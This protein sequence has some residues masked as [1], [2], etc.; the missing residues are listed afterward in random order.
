M[1]RTLVTGAAGMIGS[2]LLERLEAQAPGSA[3]GAWFLP[4]VRIEELA[5]LPLVELDVRDRDA[6]CALISA[7]RPE[8]IYHLAAQ[9]LPTV[10]WAEPATT[11][12][13]N[14]IGTV[15]LFEAVRDVRE[16]R[17]GGYDPIVVV[18]C[19]SAQ[20]GAS[21]TAE[22]VPVGEDTLQLPLHPYGVSK[23]AQ[24]LLAFQ[25]WQTRRIRCIRARI[26][27]TT[28]PR[29]R[30]DVVSDFAA[31][32]ARIMREGGALRVGNLETRRAIMDVRDLL[33]ALTLLAERGAPGEAYNICGDAACRIA[34]L[35]PIF[36]RL[37]GTKLELAPD[38][39]LFR[40][41]DEP[42]ILG[43]NTKLKERTGWQPTVGLEAT[44]RAVLDYELAHPP[45]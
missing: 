15:N 45:A 8:V 14:A 18:A 30:N 11:M 1:P 17:D 33:A 36:E 2:H 35:I 24:D 7:V 28:G 6:V 32:V 5:G 3:L 39:A 31:R 13:T 19:S 29:K 4:T 38:A 44:L 34:D 16:Q 25:Y 12:Q 9:S 40:P 10:S 37:A 27:N 26:F 20:Y 42:V 23:V 22:T 21:L 43:R 41:S